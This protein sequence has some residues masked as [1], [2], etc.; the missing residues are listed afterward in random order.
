MSAGTLIIL[1]YCRS[2]SCA[3]ESW[4]QP[5][6]YPEPDIP[7][8]YPRC[9]GVTTVGGDMLCLRCTRNHP[10]IQ[11]E[12]WCVDRQNL[13]RLWSDVPQPE[14]EFSPHAFLTRAQLDAMHP[15]DRRQMDS[16]ASDAESFH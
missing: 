5:F 8:R 14:K 3:R 9:G 4:L 1:W 16:D 10:W 6:G 2:A 7:N 11:T 13:G 15:E 12:N